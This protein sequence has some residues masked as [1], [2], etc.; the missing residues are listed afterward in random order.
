MT[1]EAQRAA[2]KI[3]IEKHTN[4]ASVNKT[5]AR[6]SLIK[7]GYLTANGELAPAY[8]GTQKKAISSR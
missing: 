4:T 2:I 7:E 6:N 3:M 8:G 5:A 1:N